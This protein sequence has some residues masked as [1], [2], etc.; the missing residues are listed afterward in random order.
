MLK[1]NL[2]YTAVTRAKSKV[3][4]IGKI[5][6]KAT[7]SFLDGV[8]GFIISLISRLR[9]STPVAVLL[10]LNGDSIDTSS[11]PTSSTAFIYS[12][13]ISFIGDSNQ[14]P[15]VGPGAVL[16]EIIASE[17]V[18]VAKLTRVYRQQSESLIALNSLLMCKS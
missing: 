4:I 15:S 10:L 8:G 14:L 6:P 5:F 12:F 18:K 9:E 11:I 16:A 13:F 2:A 1:R 17:V 7:I 3:I